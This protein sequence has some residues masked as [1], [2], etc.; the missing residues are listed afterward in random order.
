MKLRPVGAVPG[1]SVCTPIHVNVCKH[2]VIHN[3]A[4]LT[5]LQRR[6]GLQSYT[7]MWF[8]AQQC[9]ILFQRYAGGQTDRYAHHNTPLT[10]SALSF[11]ICRTIRAT[12]AICAAVSHILLGE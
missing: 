7:A 12:Y 8:H 6:Q 4:I 11:E 9:D 5:T 1:E 2:D 10:A 3:T